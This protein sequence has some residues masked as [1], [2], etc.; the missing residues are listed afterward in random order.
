MI[1]KYQNDFKE[2]H[3]RIC[4]GEEPRRVIGEYLPKFKDEGIGFI[5]VVGY[6]NRFVGELSEGCK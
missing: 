3:R 2:I 4:E 6:L 1:D 5:G